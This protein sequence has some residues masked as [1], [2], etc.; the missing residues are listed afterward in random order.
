MTHDSSPSDLPI[1]TDVAEF[2]RNGGTVME[3]LVFNHRLVI[4]ALCAL[5]TIIFG[6]ATYTKLELQAGFEKMLPKSHPY[7]INYEANKENL[8]GLG[9]TLRLAVA[10]T[11]DTIYTPEFM[12]ILEQVTDEVFFVSG[13][14][15]S[16]LKSLWTPNTRWQIVTQEGFEGG[17]VIPS[18]YDGSLASVAE[19]KVNVAR[20]GYVGSLVGNDFRSAAIQIPLMDFD[21][22][23]GERLDYYQFSS[24]LETI[25][26]RFQQKLE[27]ELGDRVGSDKERI[28]QKVTTT[29]EV[30]IRESYEKGDIAVHVTGFAKIIGEMIDGLFVVMMFFGA[31]V[32]IAAILLFWYTR[33]LR[34]TL[35]VIVVTVIAVIWQLGILSLIGYELDPFSIL[36]PFLVFA[37]GVSH[38]AQKLNGVLQDIGRGSCAYV[39]ARYTFRRLFL[40]GLTALLSD[41]VGFAVLLIIQI[42]V[43]QDLAVT[44]SIG[45]VVLIFTNLILI[46]VLLSYLGVGS[47]AAERARDSVE[48][49]SLHPLFR[50]LLNFTERRWATAAVLGGIALAIMGVIVAQDLQIGDLDKGAPELR[51]DSRYN[52]DV[53]FMINNYSVSSDI[54]AVIV[55]TPE[56]GCADYEVLS[57]ADELEWRFRQLPGV[58]DVAGVNTK[59][60]RLLSGINENYIKWYSLFPNVGTI[61]YASG[62]MVK[63]GD[64]NAEC[65]VWPML[66]YL[67]DH[68]AETLQS[69]VDTL[70]QFNEEWPSDKVVFLGAAGNAGFEAATNIVVKKANRQMLFYVYAAV[71]VLCFLTFRSLPAVI[72]AILPLMLTSVLCEA[73][74]VWLGIGVK[75][76]TLPVIALGVGIGIDYALYVL[77]VILAKNKEGLPLRESYFQTLIFTGRVVALIGVTL[78]AGVIT[79]A[80][81]PIKFQADMGI[82]LAFMFLWNMIGALVLMPALAHFLLPKP[83]EHQ[84]E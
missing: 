68:K 30:D 28:A 11:D 56:E 27:A 10:T 35:A 29:L 14:D 72:C 82:L 51:A 70:E 19:V 7:V 21:P 25:R 18:G 62:V 52:R 36:V 6:W 49:Q 38:G 41:G 37:I 79:W 32:L 59:T 34:S 44:A 67:A 78:A 24:K 8:K 26:E 64:V 58:E 9:N 39:A 65:S 83:N 1:I 2:D 46:P 76:A 16:R 73:L 60:R 55:K 5:A 53:E 57:L 40:A 17:P 81:S 77:T 42:Q 69:M 61:N 48:H 13:V 80:W 31:A 12:R 23:T 4:I 20:G 75:V 84:E 50:F 15:R 63:S 71:T 22:K 54:F 47:K 66:V 45:V 74:M 3:R 33:C 43:I